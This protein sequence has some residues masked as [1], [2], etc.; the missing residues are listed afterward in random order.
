MDDFVQRDLRIG[1]GVA[2][3]DQRKLT[4]AVEHAQLCSIKIL[5]SVKGGGRSQRR[6]QSVREGRVEAVNARAPGAG[7]VEQLDAA[8]A[9]SLKDPEFIANASADAPVLAYLPGDQWQ[10]SLEKNRKA[11]QELAKTLPKQ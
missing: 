5:G 9:E 10:Q 1:Y 11:L 4:D 3:C 6:D 7:V 8:I 2:C